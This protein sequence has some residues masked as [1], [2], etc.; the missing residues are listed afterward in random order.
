[1]RDSGERDGVHRDQEVRRDHGVRRDQG[2]GR[3]QGVRRDQEVRFGE[4]ME[5]V[6]DAN[7]FYRSKYE[8]L[9]LPGRG[10]D[11]RELASL[12]LTTKSELVADQER[13]PPYGTNLTHPLSE[14]TRVHQTSG[15]TG[16]PLRWLDTAESWAWWLDCWV[17]IYEA[18]GV[19]PEDRLFIPFSFGPFVGFWA[20]FEAGPRLGCLTVP[21]GGLTSEQRIEKLLEYDATVLVCTPTYALRLARVAREMGRDLAGSSVRLSIHAGEP[22]ASLPNVRARIE[23]TWGVRCFDHA[24]ATEVGAWGYGCGEDDHMHVNERAFIAEVIDAETLLPRRVEEDGTA[25]G[26]LVL[27]NLGRI[28][29]PVI[30]YR[31]GD[32]VEMCTDPCPCGRSGTWLRGGV[33]GRIDEMVTVRGVNVYPGAVDNIIR[34]HAGIDEYEAFVRT[35]RAMDE[36]VLRVEVGRGAT[37]ETSRALATDFHNRLQLRPTVEVVEAGT[38]PRYEMK[39]R[40]FKG[41]VGVHPTLAE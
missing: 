41:R 17:E 35:D 9:D 6:L 15:T 10:P 21:A 36:L 26:E 11:I 27:T 23:S 34:A 7:P 8:A 28:G 2:M 25:R 4:L 38:L 30:R 20:A 33:L 14:Y 40:R 24:G 29:S 18:A 32:L 12:P 31:T 39:A 37:A 3:D 13:T 22:G 1:V 5:Q 19:T 16:R